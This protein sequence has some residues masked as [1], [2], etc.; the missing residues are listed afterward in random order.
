MPSPQAAPPPGPAPQ[1]PGG[2]GPMPGGAGPMPEAIDPHGALIHQFLTQ[3]PVGQAV[4]RHTGYGPGHPKH[5][6]HARAAA[7]GGPV[8]HVSPTLSRTP[9]GPINPAL[10]RQLMSSMPGA[11]GP[12]GPPMP[13]PG[14]GPGGPPPPGPG[15]PGGPGGAPPMPMPS[16]PPPMPGRG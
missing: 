10:L 15:G 13:M 7:H 6:A 2:P 12:G 4:A 1:M 3:H 8:Q 14:G 16:T 11:G 5:D 9:A